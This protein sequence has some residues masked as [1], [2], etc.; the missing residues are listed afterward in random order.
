ML[1]NA[2]ESPVCIL[3]ATMIFDIGKRILEYWVKEC[4][5]FAFE[6]AA[7]LILEPLQSVSY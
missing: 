7:S 3:M 6:R 5:P 4:T 1:C 2:N